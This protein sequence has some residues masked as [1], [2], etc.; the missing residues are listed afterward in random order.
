MRIHSILALLLLLVGISAAQDTNFPTGPQYLMTFGSPLFARPIATPSLS[1]DSPPFPEVGPTAAVAPSSEAV[2]TTPTERQYLVNLQPNLFPIFYGQPRL[3]A[4][5]VSF[6]EGGEEESASSRP[7]L[8]G[9]ADSSVVAL[10]DVQSL[11]E[12]GYGVTLP[13]AARYRGAHKASAAHHYTNA[14]IERFHSRP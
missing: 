5:A 11:R 3:S 6:N 10:I 2:A 7:I 13:E 14:D 9:I 1:L 8:A 12:R 4:V